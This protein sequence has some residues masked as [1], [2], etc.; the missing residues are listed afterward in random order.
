MR[1]NALKMALLS[2]ATIAAM[3]ASS[4]YAQQTAAGTPINNQASVSYTVGGSTTT[5]TSNVETFLVDKKVNLAVAEVGALPTSVAIGAADQVTTFTVTNLTNAI[6]DFRLL[7]DQNYI[8]IPLLGTDDFNVTTVRVFVDGNNNGVYDASDTATFIDELAPDA[9]RTVF[10]VANVPNA[11]NQHTAIVSLIAVAADGGGAGALGVDLVATSLLAVDSPTVVDI[12][13]ADGAD[14]GDLVRNGSGRA[15][16]SYIIDSATVSIAKTSAVI[17]DPVNLAVFPKAIPGAVVRY[18]LTV[19]NAGPGIATD[20]TV[21]DV[22]PAE[23][24]FISGSI[25]VGGLGAVGTCVLGTIEDDDAVGADEIDTVG[26]S[27]D[28]GTTTVRGVLPAVLPLIPLTVSF[29]ATVK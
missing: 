25:T 23:L 24:A 13:F 29:T 16:D 5:T 26:G 1:F 28:I 9:S 22:I 8:S 6:Q 12:V 4:A 20:V 27:Y 15:Y 19:N 14:P 17:Y 18:C 21:T 7:G 2:G 3:S 10:I 11:A